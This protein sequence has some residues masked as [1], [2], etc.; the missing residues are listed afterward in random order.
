MK[1]FPWNPSN[2]LNEAHLEGGFVAT[3]QYLAEIESEN[4]NDFGDW[5]EAQNTVE[6]QEAAQSSTSRVGEELQLDS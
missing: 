4:D 5:T 3:S 1:N 2:N 6:K